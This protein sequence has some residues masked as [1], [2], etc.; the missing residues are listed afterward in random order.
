MLP[1]KSMFPSLFSTVSEF[2]E[3]SRRIVIHYCSLQ[4][5]V[6]EE[7]LKPIYL[8]RDLRNCLQVYKAHRMAK[9]HNAFFVDYPAAT[10]GAFKPWRCAVPLH[11]VGTQTV[12][13]CRREKGRTFRLRQNG[14]KE[15]QLRKQI[16]TLCQTCEYQT[17]TSSITTWRPYLCTD[18]RTQNNSNSIIGGYVHFKVILSECRPCSP[19][20]SVL[21]MVNLSL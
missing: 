18:R 15:G 9:K 19:P 7:K 14:G 4:Q 21:Y 17:T 10:R 16:K 6:V 20:P 3:Y 13:V 12:W 2:T 5:S 11:R 1:Y 8:K